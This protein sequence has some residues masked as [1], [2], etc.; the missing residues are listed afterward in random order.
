M[1]KISVNKLVEEVQSSLPREI[2]V[3]IAQSCL[4]ENT[5]SQTTIKI[6]K[7]EVYKYTLKVQKKVI[8]CT[9]TLLHTN[10]GRAQTDIDFNGESTNV[11]YDI[12]NNK[13]GKRNEFLNESMNLLLGSE[14]VCFVNNN[15]SSLFITLKTLKNIYG[16]KSLIISRGE[17]IE[18]G[19][20]YRL[21]EIIQETGLKMVEVGTTNKTKITDYKKALKENEDSLILKVHRSNF[22]IH[23]FVEEV[24]LKDLKSLTEKQNSILIHDLGSGLVASRKF[25]EKENIDIFDDEPTVQESLRQGADLVMFSGDKLFGSLQS[26]VIAGDKKIIQSIKE[27]P[28][29]RTYRCSPL[30]L[31]EL[32]ETTNRYVS[33]K[34]IE[35]PLWRMIAMKYEDLENRIKSVSENLEIK[36]EVVNDNSVMG[37]GTLPNK[38]IPTPVI[39]IREL[40]NPDLMS[41]LM[42]Y[43]IPIIPRINNNNIIIDLRSTPEKNDIYIKDFFTKL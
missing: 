14:D 23:G 37:G 25:L 36:H 41:K 26:G 42:G 22:S 12:L 19:G 9:G 30:T 7:N 27:S 28:L 24:N 2:I 17:I 4:N 1:D 5:D 38:S 35:I 16:K 3:S 18:I 21:P 39:Q 13:R 34:E 11:E 20:S 33:K 8:N 6:F 29:F 32:Q 15:A 43:E 31:F 10:L 40:E